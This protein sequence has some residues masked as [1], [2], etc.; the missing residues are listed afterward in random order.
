[1]SEIDQLKGIILVQQQHIN[2]LK[3]QLT[4]KEIWKRFARSFVIDI[5]NNSNFKEAHDERGYLYDRYDDNGNGITVLMYDDCINIR[6]DRKM[7]FYY[8]SCVFESDNHTMNMDQLTWLIR[9]YNILHY[10]EDNNE[11]NAVSEDNTDSE[12]NGDSEDNT[13]SEDNTDSE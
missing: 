10:E 11:D 12:D 8:D 4:D 7:V 3:H 2:D 1:M 6:G 9:L 5:I 13:N